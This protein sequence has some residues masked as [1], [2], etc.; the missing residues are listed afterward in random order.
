MQDFFDNA[1]PRTFA[2]MLI[3][4]VLLVGAVEVTY[5]FWP[6]LKSYRA[7]NS[8][9]E[10]LDSAMISGESLAVQL[11]RVDEEVKKLSH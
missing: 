6:Q 1:E 11:T 10:L 2:M 8:E 3:A 7:L 4:V 9:Y 5:L